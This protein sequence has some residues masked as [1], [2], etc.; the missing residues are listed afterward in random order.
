MDKRDALDRCMY[1]HAERLFRGRSRP[2]G[3]MHVLPER[4]H[5]PRKVKPKLIYRCTSC[6]VIVH[7]EHLKC[8][9]CYRG[10]LVPWESDKDAP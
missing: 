2:E 6:G 7:D 8:P 5:V 9:C 4:P 10:E 3:G 1:N